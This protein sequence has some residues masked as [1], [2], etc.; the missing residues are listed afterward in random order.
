VLAPVVRAD[1][2]GVGVLLGGRFPVGPFGRGDVEVVVV[3]VVS[4]VLHDGLAL[5]FQFGD[6]RGEGGGAFA[7]VAQLL[8]DVQELSGSSMMTDSSSSS[9]PRPLQTRPDQGFFDG[10]A[11]AQGGGSGLGGLGF[12]GGLDGG[13]G[14]PGLLGDR[15]R[16]DADQ[17]QLVVGVG[18]VRFGQFGA[19]DVL[20]HL[21]DDALCF[22]G[23]C[24]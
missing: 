3:G 16:R 5:G 11:L 6:Q 20:H 24:R 9:L 8:G 22:F 21:R 7:P 19:L 4:G 23:G 1:Q 13:L 15:G 14:P 2:D 17:G 10:V 18:F 12:Q